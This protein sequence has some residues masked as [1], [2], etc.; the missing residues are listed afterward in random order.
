MKILQEYLS[1]QKQS[2]T[3]YKRPSNIFIVYYGN[4]TMMNRFSMNAQHVKNTIQKGT[5]TAIANQKT[6]GHIHQ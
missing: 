1:I 4:H 5:E 2:E 6:N 3:Q